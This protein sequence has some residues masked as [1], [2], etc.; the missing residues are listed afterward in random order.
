MA[1]GDLYIRRNS[2][3]TSS[4]PNAGSNLDANWDLVAGEQGNAVTYSNPNFRLDTG[5]YLIM[6]CEYF[7][8]SDT[9]DNERIEIQ[10][11]IHVSGI[12]V[13]GGYGQDYIRKS[14]GQ[15][16]CIVSGYTILEVTSDDTDV[17]IRFY[18]TDNST[19]GTVDRV[20]GHGSVTILQLDDTHNYG[21]YSTSSTEST[22][23][24]T[25]RILNINT[26]DRQ[27]TGF[28]RSGTGVTVSNAGRY[29]ATYSI[30]ISQTTTGRE[31]IVARITDAGSEITG[32][33]AYCYCRGID[34][35]QDGALTWIGLLDLDGGEVL[36][37]RW[38][39]PQSA[40]FTA[41][42]GAQFQLW[43]IPAS[44]DEA[45]M[46]AT[47]GDYN[48]PGPFT[49]D[50]LPHIDTGSFTASAG[51]SNIDVD[52]NDYVLAFT[53][54]H[55]NAPDTVQRGYPEVRFA[56]DGQIVNYAAGGA[57]HRNSGGSGVVAI[58]AAGILNVTPNQSVA[59]RIDPLAARGSMN[60]DSG[61]FALL[62]LE[63]LFG[64]Y[65]FPPSITDFNT[66][67]VFIW[68]TSDRIITGANFGATQG[69]GKVEIWSDV[70]GT[71]KVIQTVDS[72]SDTS[73]QIDTVQ[74]TLG[75][76]TTLYLVVTSD[77]G[78][79]STPFT[80]NEGILPYKTLLAQLSSDHLWTLDNDYN[81]TGVT[82]PTRDMNVG[83]IGGGGAFTANPIAEDSTH[84]WHMN[85]T[86]MRRE[87]TDSVNMNITNTLDERTV[88]C[89]IQL[90]GTQQALGAIW[91][92]G[93]GV[94]NLAFIIG[95]GNVLLAQLAD[96]AGTRDNVQ[97]ISDIRLTPNR[98]YHIAMRYSQNEN[99]SEFRL[100]LD[101]K[102]QA[103]TD[104]NPMTINI[105]DSHS[106]DVVW[107]DP[108]ANL[109]TGGTDVAYNGQEDA[110]MAYFATW[111]DNSA[112]KGAL[113]KE[114]EIRDILFRRG[115]IPD[116][117]ITTGT[118]A[119]M[120]TQLDALADSEIPDWPLGIRVLNSTDGD[121]EL[122]ADNV[123]FNSR[124]SLQL[125]YRGGD[126]LTWVNEN[127]SNL[128]VDSIYAP[129]GGTVVVV[130]SVPI[131]LT[132][133]DI[134]DNTAIQDARVRVVAGSG[135]SATEGD[136]LLEGLTDINGQITAN[137]R[138]SIDQP[139]T[140]VVRKGS[141]STY[142]KST[143]ISATIQ[144]TGLT[145]NI[146]MIKDE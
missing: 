38:Q 73:I 100:Y 102:E 88:C 130:E 110:Y 75:S 116:T 84:C 118:Q 82:G 89:W 27:D 74:G 18:R 41:S 33:N 46:E 49:W 140:G 26:N 128:S 36:D 72:W 6:Y 63:S 105:F 91:K 55:Q 50:T 112:N 60:N 66:T 65:T 7:E 122:V 79:E 76:D 43:Q 114:S 56:V 120:Q 2:T 24:S 30:D 125:E 20:P 121:F 95:I 85:S 98:P 93:G 68:G 39:A 129:A 53:T 28:S 9:T 19:S 99:P 71:I 83:I 127:G 70:I 4:V 141:T 144:S 42:A 32:T 92:E 31:D 25:E 69:T 96:V 15:Q 22:S 44:A 136:V 94:Q 137:F 109:E 13:V 80:I 52:Q 12:G 87:I 59:V 16:E 47:S 133:L 62:S 58:T 21:L 132:V 45:I 29:L 35:T 115:A 117:I 135:G 131:T 145:T 103:V 134:D 3:D 77:A 81:D 61:Q 146:F 11:E 113:D 78:A 37:V 51:Q 40:T 64:P 106:G 8:T 67:E 143:P 57:Y 124:V 126:T 97:A 104:G 34:G 14:S 123:T 138:Y 101:G 111:S 90:N 142:Y 54:F 107:N 5:I 119:A 108:D 86:T 10:G 48:S 17:F 139:V 1:A 23:G